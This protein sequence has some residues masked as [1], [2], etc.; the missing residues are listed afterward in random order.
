M[1]NVE[2]VMILVRRRGLILCTLH[3]KLPFLYYF[4]VL[5]FVSEQYGPQFQQ[6]CKDTHQTSSDS[7]FEYYLTL[8]KSII[9][10]KKD[11]PRTDRRIVR[12]KSPENEEKEGGMDANQ[13][14]MEPENDENQNLPIRGKRKGK[15]KIIVDKIPNKLLPRLEKWSCIR[16]L[17]KKL[18]IFF[19]THERNFKSGAINN[20]ILPTHES[21][22]SPDVSPMCTL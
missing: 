13:E 21:Y 9:T 22:L 16:E 4:F 15:K 6:W 20:M 11:R 5:F 8:I 12:E 3:L 18:K 2:K 19:E 17:K 14:Q 1:M 10:V 7:L